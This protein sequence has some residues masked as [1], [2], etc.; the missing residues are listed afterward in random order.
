MAILY[1]DGDRFKRALIA[2]ADWL[3]CNKAELNRLNVFPVPDGD[4]GTNMS[5]TLGSAIEEVQK[6][7]GLSLD[8]V[9]QAAAWGALMGAR[10]NSGIILAQIL[11]GFAES[12]GKKP[13][14]NSLGI[15]SALQV[16]S[17]KAYQ[18]LTDPVEGTIL[19]VVREAA[20]A[21]VGL[22]DGER[23]IALLLGEVL[24][25]ARFSLQ[26]TPELLPVLKKAGVVDAGG[27]GFVYMVEGV[28]RLLRGDELQGVEV[29][30]EAPPAYD[31]QYDWSKQ[32][33]TEALLSGDN[34]PQ[35]EIKRTLAQ[36]GD[37]LMVVGGDKLLRIHIHTADPGQVLHY[38]ISFGEIEQVKVDNMRK[39]H[40]DLLG[41]SAELRAPQ[42][43]IAIVAIS[44]GNGLEEIFTGMGADMLIKGGQTMNPSTGEILS[45][46]DQA[47]SSKVIV[48][49]N[50]SNVLPAARQA[51][52][53][54]HKD[55]AVVASRTIPEG[56]S[57]LVAFREAASLEE[58]AEYM[59]DALQDTKTG[60]VTWASRNAKYGSMEIEEGDILGIFDGDIRAVGGRL[61]DVALDLLEEM[62]EPD[63]EI[64]TLFYGKDV[65]GKE[66]EELLARVEE[67]F[68]DKEAELHW[69]GQPHH[70]YLI[71]VE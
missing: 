20:E 33:C 19:T 56:L 2:G 60:E 1:C 18:A 61:Q 8:R 51:S 69:G 21:A 40:Q 25:Q 15:A 36:L 28:L 24:K 43:P 50:N 49:P 16:A 46:I 14:L 3:N 9:V 65:E 62:I 37:S 70:F 34:L 38:I 48:L 35:A 11:A 12:A 68:P 54:S 45:A 41:V 22:A 27:L 31:I 55:V 39:Q 63:D 5:L 59:E 71:S 26:N 42:K 66:A 17:D 32:Y 13:R 30:E 7:N 52:K 58:N 57:A 6:L 44:V 23:D 67:R 47:P 4:T 53:L 64:I 10:G 29:E